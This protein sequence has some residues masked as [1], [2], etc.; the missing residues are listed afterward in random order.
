MKEFYSNINLK[1]YYSLILMGIIIMTTGLF[2]GNPRMEEHDTG[3]ILH[4]VLVV[5]LSVCLIRYPKYETQVSRIIIILVASAYFYLIFFLYP[6]TWSTF[7]FLCFIPAISILFFDP[8][9]FYFSLILNGLSITATF[10]YIIFIDQ[11]KIYPHITR[12]L[13]GNIANFAG[14]QVILYLIFYLSSARINKLK[15]YYEQI[16]HQE[17]LKTT[18]QLA[19]A[20]AHE[21]RNPLTVVQGFLQL[22]REEISFSPDVKRNF[23][24]MIDELKT[25]EHVISHFL[26]FAKPNKEKKLDTIDLKYALQSVTDLLY[27]YGLLNDNKIN[28][29]VQEDCFVVANTIEFKQLITNLVK[30]AIEASK[31]GDAVTV[32]AK[33][34]RDYVEIKII[35]YGS[36]MSEAEVKSLGTPFYSLKSKGTGLGLMICYQIVEKYNGTIQFQSIKDEGTTVTLKFPIH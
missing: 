35:D 11:G 34:M 27:S 28:L 21:I 18:G 31:I 12:D 32:I 15:S 5:F 8:K 6:D 26:T 16:Q 29:N 9:L 22:Y 4:I 1:L 10:S 3:Y 33:K 24:L 2:I 23:S 14:S 17:R 36:G 7:V 25:A 19:A 30:N 20:V 13:V